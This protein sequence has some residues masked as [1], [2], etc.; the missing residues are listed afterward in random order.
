MIDVDALELSAIFTTGSIN[1]GTATSTPLIKID[2]D[3]AR[4]EMVLKV[5]DGITNAHQIQYTSDLKQWIPLPTKLIESTDLSQID[6]QSATNP[7]RFYRV[8]KQ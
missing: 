6:P 4:N 2:Y 1:F 8:I 3:V 7:Y 5:Q